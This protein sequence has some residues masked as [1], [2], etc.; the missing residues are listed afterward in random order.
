MIQP[1]AVDDLQEGFTEQQESQRPVLAGIEN[2]RV[3][4]KQEKIDDENHHV[5]GAVRKELARHPPDVVEHGRNYIWCARQCDAHRYVNR[6]SCSYNRRT[7][8]APRRAADEP[9]GCHVRRAEQ[10]AA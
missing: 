5:G 3:D 9:P 8:A 10:A 1:P 7:F 6:A 2:P 4:R